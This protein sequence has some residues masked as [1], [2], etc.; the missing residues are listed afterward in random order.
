MDLVNEALLVLV[1]TIDPHTHRPMH[2]HDYGLF[3]QM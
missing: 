3:T 2:L 1:T